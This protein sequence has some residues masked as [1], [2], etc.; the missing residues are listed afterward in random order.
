MLKYLIEKEFKAIMRNKFLPKLILVFPVMMMLLMPWAANLD[1]KD[2]KVAVVDN[3]RSQLSTGLVNK[4]NSSTYFI[5]ERYAKSYNDAKAMVQNGEVDIILEI[6]ENYEKDQVREKNAKVNISVN[7]VNGTRGAMGG[8]YLSNIISEFFS[9]RNVSG[10]TA[11]I[12]VATQT[13]Y[14]PTMDYKKFMVPALMT[15]LLTLLCG[16]LPALNIVSEK[17]AG[18]IEQINV[19]PIPKFTFIFSKLIPYWIIGFIVLTIV[20]LLAKIIYGVSPVGSLAT[21]YLLASVFVLVV[22]GLG[23][24]ISN[25]SNTMQQAMFV[26]FFFMLIMIMMAG[27]FTPV[28]SMPEWAQ[29]IA[30]INPMRYFIE[31]MRMLYL[32]GSG[33]SD[34]TRQI[35]ALALFAAAFNLWAIISYRKKN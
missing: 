29:L 14:N 20:I 6:P 28:D 3:D 8:A 12:N 7:A 5:V 4:I 11:L 19:T 34:L 17:E 9:G 35:T 13:R 22:S 26:M 32:K 33:L 21:F 25:Y 1:I 31:I 24:V 15:M 30:G 23:L 10:Q 27:L 16:F 2:I 18:T